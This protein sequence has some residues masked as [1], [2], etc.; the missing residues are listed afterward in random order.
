MDRLKKILEIGSNVAI[1]VVAIALVGFIAARYFSPSTAPSAAKADGIKPGAVIPTGDLVWDKSD[2]NLVMV[3]STACKYCN[4]SAPF[5][6]KLSARKN[7]TGVRLFA[8]LPQPKEEVSKYL[9]EKNVTVDEI[10]QLNPGQIDVR[11]TPTLLLVDRL[12]VVLEAW[13]GKLPPEKEN[14]VMGR[15]FGETRA[16]W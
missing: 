6:Q 1:I 12:G 13:N 15:V 8:V 9:S 7:G 11:G 10:V 4:E 14:E 16:N 3:L 2:K 5:Y